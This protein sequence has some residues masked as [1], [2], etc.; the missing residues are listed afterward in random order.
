LSR[1]GY[2][3]ADKGTGGWRPRLVPAEDEEIII[4]LRAVWSLAPGHDVLAVGVFG[5]YGVD[6]LRRVALDG[7]VRDP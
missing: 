3:V 6:A 4:G 7:V 5:V 2:P 1:S